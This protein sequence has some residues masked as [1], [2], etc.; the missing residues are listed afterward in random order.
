MIKE[1]EHQ[2]RGGGL[3]KNNGSF[4]KSKMAAILKSKLPVEPPSREMNS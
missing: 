3:Q 4:S 2:H 1:V